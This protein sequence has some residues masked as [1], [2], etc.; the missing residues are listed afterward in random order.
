MTEHSQM[1]RNNGE[2]FKTWTDVTQLQLQRMQ[3]MA[4]W[5]SAED[6]QIPMNKMAE[7]VTKTQPVGPSGKT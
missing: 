3:T 5:I 7:S 1:V 6:L 4:F 2:S